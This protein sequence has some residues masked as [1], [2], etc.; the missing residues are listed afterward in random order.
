[1]G[2]KGPLNWPPQSPDLTPLDFFLWG[3]LKDKVYF[4]QST[5]L[6]HLKQC[7]T[8]ACNS[9]IFEMLESVTTGILE[10]LLPIFY[11]R[12]QFVHNRKSQT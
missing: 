5:S 2:T 4:Q 1:M 8:E 7:I 3:Y 9:L 6:D 12:I 11:N 10:F